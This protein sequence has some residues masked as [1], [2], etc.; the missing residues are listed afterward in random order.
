MPALR[1]AGAAAGSPGLQL[2]VLSLSFLPILESIFFYP[3][4]IVTAQANTEKNIPSPD[5]EQ[6]VWG[7]P[8]IS[9]FLL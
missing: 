3:A 2:L 6:L 8:H 5:N 1:V 4:S 7:C 9:L